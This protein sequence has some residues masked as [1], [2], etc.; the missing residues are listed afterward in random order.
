MLPL[1]LH[2]RMNRR[3]G[4]EQRHKICRKERTERLERPA[5][6]RLM[7]QRVPG[8]DKELIVDDY[9]PTRASHDLIIAACAEVPDHRRTAR[10]RRIR[11]RTIVSRFEERKRQHSVRRQH[12]SQRRNKLNHFFLVHV[13]EDGESKNKIKLHATVR[14]GLVTNPVRVVLRAV[15][16]E[17]NK[18]SA[19]IS[20]ASLRDHRRVEIDAPVVFMV[21]VVAGAF[22][23]GADVATEVENLF[24]LP[25]RTAKQF[26]EV[27]KL[28][29]PRRYKIPREA[30]A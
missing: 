22:Q 5:G 28:R 1:T 23:K 27:R 9:K 16:I 14:N 20:R 10:Q 13:R 24:S 8:F 6:A 25:H 21:H 29:A 19:W 7:T 4:K 3:S 12:P 15:T 30:V 26:V 2:G 18:M 17:V 11:Q